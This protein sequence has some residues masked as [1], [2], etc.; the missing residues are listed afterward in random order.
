MSVVQR[1]TP[2]A[3]LRTPQTIHFSYSPSVLG[4]RSLS[5]RSLP[6]FHLNLLSDKLRIGKHT[7]QKENR[8]THSESKPQG[9]LF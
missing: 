7:L 6:G 9:L 8:S 3:S 5:R 2:F 4:G 1:K